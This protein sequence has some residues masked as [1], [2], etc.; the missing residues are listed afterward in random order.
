MVGAFSTLLTDLSKDFD[1][2]P[3]ELLIAKRHEY[4]FD[5]TLLNL[6]Y[7]HIDHCKHCF[8]E[9]HWDQL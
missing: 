7:G 1:C 3:H 4:G 2:F 8:M 9:L 5:I 6:L